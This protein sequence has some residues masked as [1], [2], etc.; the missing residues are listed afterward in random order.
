MPE[1][2]LH[3]EPPMLLRLPLRA[4]HN[5]RPCGFSQRRQTGKFLEPLLMASTSQHDLQQTSAPDRSVLLA[6]AGMLTMAT[7]L[8]IDRFVY[9]PILPIMAEAE[10]LSAA[11]AGL[12]ASANFLGCLVGA[13]TAARVE[14][15]GSRRGWL[16]GKL[17]LSALSTG[18]TGLSSSLPAF[19]LVRFLGG[20]AGAFAIVV[21]IALVVDVLAANGR[22]SLIALHFGGVGIGIAASA[23]LVSVLVM[24]G[25]SWRM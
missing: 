14:L 1:V 24:A 16:V 23:A 12:I 15:P 21:A 17:A 13:L 25:S 6:T 19:L 4:V 22:R 10:Q 9:T 8:G 5:S 18:V 11:E 20:A 7:A 2:D 3:C